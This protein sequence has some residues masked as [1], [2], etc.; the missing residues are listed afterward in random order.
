[1]TGS[2]GRSKVTAPLFPE[3]SPLELWTWSTMTNDDTLNKILILNIFQATTIAVDST[4]EI[5]VYTD[6]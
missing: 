4:H 3:D 2:V 1:M 5:A 6:K